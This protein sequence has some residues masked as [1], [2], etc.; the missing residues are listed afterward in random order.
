MPLNKM[1]EPECKH[2]ASF[3]FRERSSGRSDGSHVAPL[4]LEGCDAE[5]LNLP[6]TASHVVN[7]H[8]R[9][10]R[11]ISMA[12]PPLRGLK[13]EARPEQASNFISR[14][15]SVSYLRSNRQ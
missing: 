13:L 10:R 6:G 15:R 7:P 11:Q 12:L 2:H 1:Y 14:P 3:Q 4:S 8:A 9:S 5:R